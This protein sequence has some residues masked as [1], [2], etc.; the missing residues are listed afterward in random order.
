MS[1]EK[2]I[3]EVETDDQTGA[4]GKTPPPVMTVDQVAAYLQVGDRSIYNMA[5]AGE[6]PAVKVAGQWRFVKSEIDRW[7]SDLA[8][9]NLKGA[10][11]G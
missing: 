6:I 4:G 11:N 5:A 9:K 8:R 2:A 7:L 1:E 3:Y 10:D